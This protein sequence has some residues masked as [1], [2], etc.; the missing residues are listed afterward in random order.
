MHESPDKGERALKPLGQII[1]DHLKLP[2]SYDGGFSWTRKRLSDE[3][4]FRHFGRATS[5]PC[6][7]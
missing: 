6:N 7:L 5:R 2:P 4:E 1:I 3:V